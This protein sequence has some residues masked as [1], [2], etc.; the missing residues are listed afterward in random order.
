MKSG[1]SVLPTPSVM[2][3]T[4]DLIAELT[5]LVLNFG[6][7]REAESATVDAVMTDLSCQ[8]GF[9][10]LDDGGFPTRQRSGT[11][12]LGDARLLIHLA[13]GDEGR[14]GEQ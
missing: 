1:K 5:L 11:D 8:V 10:A 6:A 3:Q 14:G 4:V 12:A 13:F 2:L 7:F 9:A